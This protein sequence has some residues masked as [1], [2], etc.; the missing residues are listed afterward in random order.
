MHLVFAK[1]S[2]FVRD[3]KIIHLDFLWFSRTFKNSGGIIL[4]R[5]ILFLLFESL[6]IEFFMVHLLFSF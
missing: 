6:K 1:H 5:Q 4:S 3:Y 2:T